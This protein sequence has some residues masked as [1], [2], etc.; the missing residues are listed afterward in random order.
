MKL[1]KTFFAKRIRELALLVCDAVIVVFCTYAAL[2]ARFAP[3]IDKSVLD[4][5]S[6]FLPRILV[7][8]LG[9][10]KSGSDKDFNDMYDGFNTKYALPARD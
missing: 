3:N 10:V 6:S 4:S 2:L 7:S 8:Y 5:V 1:D 9:E